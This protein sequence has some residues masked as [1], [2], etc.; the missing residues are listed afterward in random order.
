MIQNKL[1]YTVDAKLFP[2]VLRRLDDHKNT[3]IFAIPDDKVYELTRE[4]LKMVPLVDDLKGK[5]LMRNRYTKHI[6][7]YHHPYYLIIPIFEH[8][9]FKNGNVNQY[10]NSLEI[11]MDKK[12]RQDERQA[13]YFNVSFITSRSRIQTFNVVVIKL[14]TNNNADN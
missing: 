1:L 5:E 10:V 7:V 11:S 12:K 4:E 9:A 14:K 13:P 3:C 6:L 8:F 2:K